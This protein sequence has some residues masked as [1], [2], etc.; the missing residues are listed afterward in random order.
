MCTAHKKLFIK[1][2]ICKNSKVF[3]PKELFKDRLVAWPR[4]AGVAP[5]SGVL[6]GVLLPSSYG[7]QRRLRASAYGRAV[8]WLVSDYQSHTV[9]RASF[10]APASRG[11]QHRLDL[12]ISCW[13]KGVRATLVAE[14][15]LTA[16][17]GGER[18]GWAVVSGSCWQS[19][20]HCL[21][22]TA[23]I[24]IIAAASMW[25]WDDRLLIQSP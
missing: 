16:G 17:Y 15:V 7:Q 23:I 1:T 2:F 13:C 10:Q 24:I 11:V 4:Q 14:P 18:G 5:Q 12:L 9:V 21:H 8:W 19:V 22:Q 3:F 6:V 25:R 20:S